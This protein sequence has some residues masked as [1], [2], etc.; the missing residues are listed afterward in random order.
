MGMRAKE[1]WKLRDHVTVVFG[2]APIR[3]ALRSKQGPRCR[4]SMCLEVHGVRYGVPFVTNRHA[5]RFMG[6][7]ISR[8]RTFRRLG[9]VVRANGNESFQMFESLDLARRAAIEALLVNGFVRL[10]L[11]EQ[12]W[13]RE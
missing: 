8:E 6:E 4:W 12:A 5:I 1:V 9:E 10:S 13:L 11:D 7:A 3:F 2:L